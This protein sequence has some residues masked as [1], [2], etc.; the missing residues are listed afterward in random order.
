MVR[1]REVCDETIPL[2]GNRPG[3]FADRT[4]CQGWRANRFRRL[5]W[6]DTCPQL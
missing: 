2:L 3:F 1:A 4:S 5:L 6:W